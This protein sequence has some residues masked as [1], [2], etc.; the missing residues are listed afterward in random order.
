VVIAANREGAKTGATAA[1]VVA[2]L[3]L[4]VLPTAAQMTNLQVSRFAPTTA[5]GQSI[6]VPPPAALA[7]TVT[8]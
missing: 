1:G 8:R 2:T 3:V 5:T 4:K 6:V 7:L